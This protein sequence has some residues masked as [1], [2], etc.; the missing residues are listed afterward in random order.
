MTNSI[1][2]AVRR[3][4]HYCPICQNEIVVLDKIEVKGSVWVQCTNPACQMH[5]I[6]YFPRI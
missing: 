3:Q 1:K 2:T 4:F 5:G 6:L